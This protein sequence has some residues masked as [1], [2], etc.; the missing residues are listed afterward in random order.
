MGNVVRAE[1]CRRVDGYALSPEYRRRNLTPLLGITVGG[2]DQGFSDIEVSALDNSV[3]LGVIG[4]D[5]D[6]V[7]T[8]AVTEDLKRGNV[9]S[10]IVR[11][12]GFYC[13]VVAENVFE[14]EFGYPMVFSVR[15]MRYSGQAEREQCACVMYEKPLDCG[16]LI[17]SIWTIRNRP[18]CSGT[19]G[20][21]CD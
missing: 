9:R 20:G 3:G 11:D 12:N 6:V 17:V 8:I 14:D 16:I 10:A 15:S 21:I 19:V 1:T 18:P 7:D 4:R 5:T 13:T 2:L